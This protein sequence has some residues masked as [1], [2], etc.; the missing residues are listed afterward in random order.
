VGTTR[1]DAAGEA[2]DKTARLLGLGYPGGPAIEALAAQAQ[3]RRFRLPRA[4]VE[5]GPY[6]FSFSGVKTATQE[7]YRQHSEDRQEIAWALQ[8]A[9]VEAL[10]EKSLKA[11]L[12]LGFGRL[13]A[14]GGVTAN[15]YFRR[16]LTAE[17]RRKGVAVYFPEL[18][19]CTD[20]AAMVAA[21]GYFRA[22]EDPNEQWRLSPDP[23]WRL[24]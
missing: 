4:K 7:L 13:Y 15:Q 18:V 3:D 9:V 23:S 11:A 21:L 22:P 16:R 6:D 2:F 8:D 20:N 5:G 24:S 12:E 1:D 14:A 10:V 19:W 17:A